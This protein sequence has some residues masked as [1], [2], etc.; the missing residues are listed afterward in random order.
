MLK[1]H[2][3]IALRNLVKNRLSSFIN[4][5]GLAIGI[6]AGII[7]FL[8]AKNELTYNSNHKKADRIF[9]V[10]KE[11]H[12]PTGIQITRDTWF[13]MAK[14]LQ[15]KYSEVQEATHLWEQDSWVQVSDK[16]FN[17]PVTYAMQNIFRIFTFPLQKGDSAS[18][19][20]SKYAAIISRSTAVKLFGNEDPIGKT[21]IID[22]KTNYIVSGVFDNI[23]ENSTYRPEIMVPSASVPWY[24]NVKEYW[25]SSWLD[26]YVLLK[27]GI[28]SDL[29]ESE[30]PGFVKNNMGNESDKTLKLKL[31]RFT[32]LH[33]E[34]THANSYAYLLLIIA[35][36]ILLIASVNFINLSTANSLERYKEIGVQKV[37]GASGRELILKF[38]SESLM[39]SFIALFAG[40]IVAEILIPYFNHS[41]GI[42]LSL[43]DSNFVT[44][45]GALITLGLLTG[46]I[47]GIYPSWLITKFRPAQTLTGRSGINEKRSIVKNGLIVFQF[48]LA[49]LMLIGTSV[50]IKQIRFMKNADLNINK[51]NLLIIT[52]SKSDF[53]DENAAGHKLETFKSELRNYS[54]IDDVTSSSMSIPSENGSHVFVYPDD[55]PEEK[56]LRERWMVVD[57]NFFKTYGIKFIAGRNFSRDLASDRDESVI[58]NEAA[59]KDIGWADRNEGK[60][61]V[62]GK[63]RKIIGVVENYNY[64]SLESGIEPMIHIFGGQ[65]SNAYN[66]ITVRILPGKTQ[67]ALHYLASK[68]ITIDPARPLPYR[69]VDESFNNLY[70][71]ESRLVA[72]G[73]TF[74]II[75]FI[76]ACMGLVALSAL[77]LAYKTK[78]IGIRKVLGATV[79]GLTMML[80]REFTKW[81]L[82]ANV[83]AWPLSYYLM[84]KLLEHFAYR[85]PVNF[86]IYIIAGAVTLSVAIIS[87]GFQS[88]KTALANPVKTL[89]YE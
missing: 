47:S 84:D 4:I 9:Q 86:W 13:P 54:G 80:T 18:F 46:L 21:I 51:S 34:T 77:V 88:V 16:K 40:I 6:A 74:T 11:R 58:V 57:E 82:L 38:L 68:W 24:N 27:P 53:P 43:Q 79:P 28:N 20:D 19:G 65:E 55:R 29:L 67:E 66:Y 35:F 26:T 83:I 78:E 50:M 76:I 70:Q 63:E 1:N 39:I 36:A 41:F 64:Q 52:A 44:T 62:L 23:P 17:I 42:H 12:I 72:I 48:V 81:V 61:K 7:M 30:L 59:L 56:R 2:L 5:A 33:N 31:T 73:E 45:V 49:V 87:V 15:E 3:K 22:F 8:Y 60:I 71:S 32:D 10:Y 89:R 85:T 14:A 69:F 25:G 37:L 75:A